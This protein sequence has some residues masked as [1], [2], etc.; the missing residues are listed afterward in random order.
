MAA[1]YS[2]V[3]VLFTIIFGL[4]VAS[5]R[6]P[7]PSALPPSTAPK[8]DLNRYIGKWHEVARLPA[9]FQKA[10]EA[11]IAEYGINEDGTLAV[12]N[13]AIRANGGERD[14]KGRAIILNPPVNTKLEVSF[15]TWFAWFI[16]TSEK[17]NYW[18]LHVDA[19]YQEAIVGTPDRKFLWILA[20]SPEIPEHRRE[21]LVKIGESRGYDVSRLIHNN[22]AKILID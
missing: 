14:I 20:R 9:P 12:R 8:I 16:P 21:A 19:R 13:I 2:R 1:I 7:G 22:G 4:A 18:I 6:A 11:A 15:D 17:G 10:N 5:C 3:R